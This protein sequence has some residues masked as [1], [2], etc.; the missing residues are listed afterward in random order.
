MQSNLND[1][2]TDGD[3]QHIHIAFEAERAAASLPRLI[4]TEGSF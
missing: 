2:F 1:T 4:R 3:F